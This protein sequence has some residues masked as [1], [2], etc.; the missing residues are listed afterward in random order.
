MRGRSWRGQGPSSG[1]TPGSGLCLWCGWGAAGSQSPSWQLSAESCPRQ[2]RSCAPGTSAG[3]QLQWPAEGCGG[4]GVRGSCGGCAGGSDDVGWRRGARPLRA[5]TPSPLLTQAHPHRPHTGSCTHQREARLGTRRLHV[6]SVHAAR[7][8]KPCPLTRRVSRNLNSQAAGERAWWHVGSKC[9]VG[10]ESGRRA[11]RVVACL[12]GAG[13]QEQR[14]RARCRGGRGG[15]RNKRGDSNNAAD[16]PAQPTPRRARVLGSQ[17]TQFVP[18]TRHTRLDAP[19]QR[20][21]VCDGHAG[22][23]TLPPPA[24]RWCALASAVRRSPCTHL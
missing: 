4:G 22:K 11:R 24:S 18:P 9:R 7:P 14:Q 12:W 8:T 1:A 5:H 16:L 23:P 10:G 15:A 17:H 19:L 3:S 2:S 21:S 13:Q 6:G 20:G